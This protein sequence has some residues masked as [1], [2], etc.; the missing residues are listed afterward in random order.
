MKLTINQGVRETIAKLETLFDEYD[1]LGTI[2][3][4]RSLPTSVAAEAGINKKAIESAIVSCAAKILSHATRGR[5]Y[6]NMT[7]YRNHD[8]M[9]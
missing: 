2:L 6:P 8:W 5:R 7:D 4:N 1:A 9:I 3:S